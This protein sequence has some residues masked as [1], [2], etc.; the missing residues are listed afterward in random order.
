MYYVA[1]AGVTRPR[2]FFFFRF[3]VWIMYSPGEIDE[4]YRQGTRPVHSIAVGKGSGSHDY[5]YIM[6]QA[7]VVA[8]ASPT[9]GSL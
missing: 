8:V 5:D 9:G 2:L 3:L 1:V 4:M 6:C 7:D